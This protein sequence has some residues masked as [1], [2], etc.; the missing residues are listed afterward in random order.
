MRLTLPPF[1]CSQLR[2]L[3]LSSRIPSMKNSGH[4]EKLRAPYA[5]VQAVTYQHKKPLCQIPLFSAFFES[6]TASSKQTESSMHEEGEQPS[7]EHP[8]RI[9]RPMTQKGLTRKSLWFHAFDILGGVGGRKE[10]GYHPYSTK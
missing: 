8:N 2:N 3:V 1:F 6:H 5:N 9:Q 7:K 10:R 4:P